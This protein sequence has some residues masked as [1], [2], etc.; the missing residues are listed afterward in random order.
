VY[1][2]I[3]NYTYM[4]RNKYCLTNSI[5]ASVKTSTTTPTYVYW[6]DVDVDAPGGDLTDKPADNKVLDGD[7]ADAPRPGKHRHRH[8][9]GTA[10]SAAA[11]VVDNVLE[12]GPVDTPWPGEVSGNV[13]DI[14]TDGGNTADNLDRSA[15]P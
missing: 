6:E 10:E 1:A 15:S 14:A 11:K 3:D 2:N 12:W 8:K 4:C 5:T 9:V 13:T 7:L